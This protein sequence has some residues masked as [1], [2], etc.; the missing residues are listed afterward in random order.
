MRNLVFILYRSDI[1][2]IVISGTTICLL[3]SPGK[4]WVL[5]VE[6]DISCKVAYWKIEKELEG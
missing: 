5:N 1:V 2:R 6:G 4:K 3:P